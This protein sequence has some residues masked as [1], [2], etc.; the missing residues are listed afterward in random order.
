MKKLYPKE[1][2]TEIEFPGCEGAGFPKVR[3]PVQ[4]GRRIFPPPCKQC[5]GKAR[6]KISAP[7]KQASK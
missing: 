4:P 1:V 3:Q 5:F 7:L 2:G 6:T